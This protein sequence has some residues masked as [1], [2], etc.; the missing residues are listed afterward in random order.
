MGCLTNYYSSIRPYVDPMPQ[1]YLFAHG[2]TLKMDQM[3]PALIL[4]SLFVTF[5][6]FCC[7]YLNLLKNYILTLL[8]TNDEKIT[9]TLIIRKFCS[10]LSNK[11]HITI[12]S[13]LLLQHSSSSSARAPSSIHSMYIYIHIRI[14]HSIVFYINFI[15]C[16]FFNYSTS[17]LRS[18][19]HIHSF[20]LSLYW[21]MQKWKK[22][23][24]IIRTNLLSWK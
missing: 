16:D 19:V 12:F 2:F 14:H 21:W 15:A 10:V 7:V 6:P 13:L 4:C 5:W 9:Q 11:I 3:V 23:I 24:N 1:N 17:F 22:K 18:N 8:Y 20:I